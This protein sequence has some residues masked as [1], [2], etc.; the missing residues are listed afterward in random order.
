MK[1]GL[2][3]TGTAMGLPGYWKAEEDAAR[4]EEQNFVRSERDKAAKDD[5]AYREALSARGL[6]PGQVLAK[7]DMN[8]ALNADLA[9]D[10][11]VVQQHLPMFRAAKTPEEKSAVLNGLFSN[12]SIGANEGNLVQ[13][14]DDAMYLTNGTGSPLVVKAGE[15][16]TRDEAV[17][18]FLKDIMDPQWRDALAA[19]Q[20][21]YEQEMQKI[22][23]KAEEDR[24]TSDHR[25]RNNMM[26]ASSKPLVLGAGHV[27]VDPRTGVELAR[28][29]PVPETQGMPAVVQEAEYVMTWL[30][31]DP[32][33]KNASESS[34]RKAAFDIA[35]AKSNMPKDEFVRAM[36]LKGMDTGLYN[37]PQEAA[38]AARKLADS[39]YGDASS[40]SGSG[41]T[42]PDWRDY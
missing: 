35:T 42:T 33:Y 25:T 19:K 38:E 41:G 8:Q 7:S 3:P 28:G 27:A 11:M 6:N 24:K 29:L 16:K 39:L 5:K 20:A 37:S 40:A 22:N 15:G 32:K 36:A 4:R 30:R 23:A 31:E 21:E 13:L 18:G 26:V 9:H 14:S 17:E 34:L 1:T 2:V 10:R 12:L